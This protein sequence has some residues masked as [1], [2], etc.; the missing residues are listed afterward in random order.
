MRDFDVTMHVFT[1]S[2]HAWTFV[3]RKYESEHEYSVDDFKKISESLSVENGCLFYG[4][5]VVIPS[6]LKQEVLKILHLGHFGMQRMKQLART[7][8]YWPR[9]DKDITDTCH[10]CSS[11][12]EFQNMPAKA[13][14]HPWMLPEKPWSRIHVDHAIN[15]MGTNWLVAVDSYSK[16]PC[17][18][19]TNSV[20]SKETMRLLEE[21]FSHFGYPHTIVSDSSTSYKS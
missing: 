8:V 13:A 17:I 15:F 11:C 16:Y 2:L 6:T 5:R 14:N 12:S 21:D 20:S 4:A 10:T 19:P 7:A 9:L 1:Q 3:L 18:H